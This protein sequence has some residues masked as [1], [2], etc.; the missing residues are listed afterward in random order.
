MS[1][2]NST[3][4]SSEKLPQASV[5]KKKSFSL[6]WIVP[7]VA[8]L[9]G[10]GL[11]YTAMTEKGPTVIITFAS[12]EGLEAGKTK[13][14][15][16]DVE[17]GKVESVELAEDFEH[18]Q[19]TVSLVKRANTYLNEET[20]FWVVRPRLSGGS[21]TGLGTL[22]SGAYIAVDPGKG[23]ESQYE[24]IGLEI[25]PVVT[26]DTP[27][28]LF[29]LKATDL[30][31][32]DYGSP[33][34]Y[35]GI[36][37]GQVVGYELQKGGE[38]ID[39]TVFVDAPYDEYVKN[40]SRFW[41]ASGMDLEM[42][43]DGIRFDTESLV[44]LLIGGISLSNPAHLKGTPVADSGDIFQLFPTREAAM[45]EQ[46]IEKEYYVLKFAQSVR[47]LAIGAP[48]EFKGFPVGHVVDIGIEFDWKSGEVLVPVRI[49][50]EQE[51]LKRIASST[52]EADTGAMLDLLIEHGL[53]GQVRTGNL[54]TGK[55]YVALDFF[56]NVEP[57]KLLSENGV[58]EIPTTPT[59][60][61]ELTSNMSALLEK[62]QKVPMEEIGNNAVET[63]QS[64][65]ETSEKLERLADSDELRLTFQKA[66]ETME[67]ANNLLAKDSPTVVELQRALREMSEAARAV[68]SL[69]DQLERH[70]E[71][72]LRGKEGK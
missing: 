28:K 33:I 7:L 23:G 72:L 35:R 67:G 61:E 36:K 19:V 17:I 41:L 20:R 49:E 25:P 62:L 47:G 69:A 24:F 56:K 70:P 39:I 66:H 57:A 14:K 12:A 45:K 3:P 44:S 1:E 54:L 29:T 59:P 10:L 5:C 15:Y 65:K 26:E 18:V 42:D 40:T 53:R 50:V 4:S 13:V 31:S 32:L 27:G 60:I 43:A 55:L 11:V 48:V 8:L 30:G 52:G 38:G 37:I 6:I 51:R 34:Y 63:L 21:V 64:I 16:K 9:I 46:F 58:T 2:E 71:S 22:L 68:R